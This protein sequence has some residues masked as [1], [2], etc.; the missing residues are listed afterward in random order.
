MRSSAPLTRAAPSCRRASGR[1]ASVVKNHAASPISASASRPIRSTSRR[2]RATRSS[3]G[4]SVES[5]CRRVSPNAR[6]ETVS[7][8]QSRPSMSTVAKP[9]SSGGDGRARAGRRRRCS[10]TSPPTATCD[11]RARAGEQ[12]L[13]PVPRGRRRSARARAARAAP[14]PACWRS[15]LSTVWRPSRSTAASSS[16]PAIA[17]PTA[18]AS[19]AASVSRARRLPRQPHGRSAQPT[20]RTVCSVRGSPPAS[21]LRRR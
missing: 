8:R 4:A 6:S 17:P 20:P 14:R 18:T 7:E 13:G 10:T 2:I 19:S 21:S 5:T 3:T 16:P 11:E 15:S 1:T 9:S 12:R